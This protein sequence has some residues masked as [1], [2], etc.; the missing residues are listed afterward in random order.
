MQV[1]ENSVVPYEK[2]LPEDD[3][4][5]SCV[6]FH[7]KIPKILQYYRD[8]CALLTGLFIENHREWKPV[9]DSSYQWPETPFNMRIAIGSTDKS[10]LN[11]H[12]KKPNIL[13]E[14]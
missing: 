13:T 11:T 10:F 1:L 9:K 12:Y 14:D 8:S 2:R 4:L 7:H 3:V 5:R 6:V